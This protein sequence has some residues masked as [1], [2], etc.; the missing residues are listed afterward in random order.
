MDG[1]PG[2]HDGD[3]DAP[4]SGSLEPATK[5]ALAVQVVVHGTAS[6][7][8]TMPH[9]AGAVIEVFAVTGRRVAQRG[10]GIL[11]A[12]MHP[13]P[14]AETAALSP[15]IYFA[16]VR[17]GVES[18]QVKFALFALDPDLAGPLSNVLWA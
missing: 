2:A 13:V 5:L 16:R 1:T 12:G 9:E 3:P 15:G 8:F 17:V 11:G 10:L 18:V 6:V 4:A 7:R 14:P